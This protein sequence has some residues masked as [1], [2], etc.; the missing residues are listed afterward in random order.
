MVVLVNHQKERWSTSSENELVEDSIVCP[1]EP[2][3]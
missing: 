2:L 1:T 3:H